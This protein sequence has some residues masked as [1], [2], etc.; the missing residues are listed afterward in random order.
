MNLREAGGDGRLPDDAGDARR[1]E[2][3]GGE[4]HTC[5]GSQGPCLAQADLRAG[6]GTEEAGV[7]SRTEV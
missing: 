6:G 5:D 4:P 7:M 3:G 1:V 2:D